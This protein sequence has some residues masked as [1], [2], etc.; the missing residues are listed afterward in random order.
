MNN[1][2]LRSALWDFVLTLGV[3]S[4]LCYTLL[5][6]FYIA[7]S[8]QYGPVPAL[9]CAAVL[10]ALFGISANRS[11]SRIGIPVFAIALVASWVAAAAVTPDGAYLVD[12]ESNYLIFVMCTTVTAVVCF[13]L[14][15]RVPGAA[16]LFIAGS[17]IV[18]I[19]Q[20]LYDRGDVVWSVLFVAS[21]LALIVFK[22]YQLSLRSSTGLKKVAFAPG[23][24]VALCT[25]LVAVGLGCGIWFGVLAPLNPPAAEIKLLT[26]YRALETVR[27]KGVADVY[28]VPNIDMTSDK[29]NDGE[30]TTDDIKES[31]DGRPYPATGE[32][33]SQENEPEDSKT[34]PSSSFSGINMDSTNDMFDFLNY[35]QIKWTALIVSIMLIAAIVAYFVGRRV[36]RKRRLA[37]VQQMPVSEQ[38]KELYLFF[39]NRFE[40]LGIRI[41]PGQTLGDYAVANAATME[42]FDRE[43]GASFASLTQD[44][45]AAAYGNQEL[46][47]ASSR[48]FADYYNAFWKACRRK[49]GAPRYLLKSF[50]L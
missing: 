45:I 2:Y 37:R 36:L 26:E 46:G 40:R 10:V 8:L 27:I 4:S 32:G 6:C 47:E 29:T 13:A 12:S 22:N 18:G 17:F 30:R 15:R 1:L 28:Q 5:N 39:V 31:A 42:Q 19:V 43:A 11:V 14:S 16:L 9:V 20:F 41:A 38:V 50:R 44:Y 7:E 33:E 34:P 35:K 48:K 23:F 25:A 24:A 49:L 3:T 21:S